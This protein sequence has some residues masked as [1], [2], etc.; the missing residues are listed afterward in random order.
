MKRSDRIGT[1]HADVDF[2]LLDPSFR[3]VL[4]LPDPIRRQLI[5]LPA[6][7]I[8]VVRAECGMRNVAGR[9]GLKAVAEQAAG[10]SVLQMHLIRPLPNQ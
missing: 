7:W 6:S 5:A 4:L 3:I 8:F 10:A 2:A 1:W 9:P